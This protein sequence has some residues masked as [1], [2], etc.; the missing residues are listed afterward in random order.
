MTLQQFST[1]LSLDA[2]SE[3]EQTVRE[4][5]TTK[6]ALRVAIHRLRSRYRALLRSEIAAT[7]AS[8]ELVDE[9][10]RELFCAVG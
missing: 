1:N 9:E 7:V 4:L 10:M 2:D 8:P 3:C 6:G 5:G